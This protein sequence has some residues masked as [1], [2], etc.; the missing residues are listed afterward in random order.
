MN[1]NDT[2]VLDMLNKIIAIN[3]L[4]KIQILDT[5][6]LAKISGNIDELLDN[7]KWENLQFKYKK[8]IKNSTFQNI[9]K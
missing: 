1:I 6:K 7:M 3:R 8:N 9:C 5:I 4:N 2:Y